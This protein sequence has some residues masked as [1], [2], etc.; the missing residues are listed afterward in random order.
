MLV[1]IVN[2]LMTPELWAVCIMGIV[3]LFLAICDLSIIAGIIFGNIYFDIHHAKRFLDG[4]SMG[5]ISLI[6]CII[7][8]AIFVGFCFVG[9]KLIKEFCDIV[10]VRRSEIDPNFVWSNEEYD[11]DDDDD[12]SD[13]D[14]SDDDQNPE[15]CACESNLT[16][17]DNNYHLNR[18]GNDI[19]AMPNLMLGTG[20]EIA[21]VRME[22]AVYVEKSE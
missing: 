9:K 19:Y 1:L 5:A 17:I 3:I 18:Y 8:I 12:S 14:S 21:L 22:E 7:S 10:D 16:P 15:S 4:F 11:S 6:L 13:N 20:K 2:V